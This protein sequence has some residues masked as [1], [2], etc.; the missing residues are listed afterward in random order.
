M[1]QVFGWLIIL[2][3]IGVP[4][5]LVWSLL[6]VTVLQLLVFAGVFACGWFARDWKG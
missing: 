6:N 2:I 4:V 1:A 5:L 3:C